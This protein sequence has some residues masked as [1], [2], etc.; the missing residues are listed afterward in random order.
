MFLLA[1]NEGK[2]VETSLRVSS[3]RGQVDGSVRL[4]SKHTGLYK[5]IKSDEE[6]DKYRCILEATDEGG[7][8]EMRDEFVG[9]IDAS[10]FAVACDSWTAFL[11]LWM[12][13]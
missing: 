7:S 9:V 3:A 4:A 5:L 6:H 12:H 10:F 13:Y 8:K 1:T 2:C 11:L